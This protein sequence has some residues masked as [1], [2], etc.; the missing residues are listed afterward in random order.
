M[1]EV[2]DANAYKKTDRYYRIV[3]PATN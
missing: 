3:A 1:V 2:P